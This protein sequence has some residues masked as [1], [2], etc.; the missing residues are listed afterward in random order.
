MKKT[1]ILF[2]IA[3]L[4]AV[5]CGDK[6][7]D[8]Y[9]SVNE[10]IHGIM[11]DYYLWNNTIP[12]RFN[13]E[14]IY[15]ADYFESLLFRDDRW[16]FISED[17]QALN[18]ELA[19]SPYSMGYSPQFWYYNNKKNVLIVVEYVYPGSPAAR[20]GLKRGDIIIDI[21][22]AALTPDN[23]YDLYL[24][25]R[26]SFTM[27]YY[28]AANNQ[29]VP[30]GRVLTMQAEKVQADPSIYDTIFEVNGRSVGYY[31]YTAFTTG[32]TYQAS[33]DAVFDRFKAAGV[34][35]L[36]LDLRYNGGGD[37]ETAR[38]L[39]S[40]IAPANTID[41]QEILVT[42][43]YNDLLTTVFAQEGSEDDFKVRFEKNSHNAD[44][45]NL[46]VLCAEG[47]ASASEMVTI[48][49]MPYMNVTLVGDTTYGKYTGMFVFDSSIDDELKDLKNWALLPVCMKFANANGF[50]DFVDG[51]IPDYLV[52]DD[53]LAG[54][55]FGDANDP[56][57]A[58][59][60]DVIQGLPLT[61]KAARIN[62]F[63]FVGR[64]RSVFK[65]NL[66][67]KPKMVK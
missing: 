52:E 7:S 65:N 24:K 59:A 17:G 9:S 25:E 20:A 40:A 6:N 44:M 41:K 49:L 50:T 57:I 39:A 5:A 63:K 29:L 3:A 26:A 14:D 18:D 19:G 60:L 4:L 62:P 28:D 33:M 67:M 32:R 61:A 38:H 36:I 1:L 66:L 11:K 27:A 12:R 2:G 23:Y 43:I 47:T 64:D 46:Y 53:L 34:K 21:N 30:D 55:Q 58:T 10:C 51:L 48:G 35:D 16:S 42:N 37:V 45:E 13:G 15:P 8:E 31:V 22:N 56:M 54:Y